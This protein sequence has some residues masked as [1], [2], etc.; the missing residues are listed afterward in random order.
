MTLKLSF[1]S[2]SLSSFFFFFFFFLGGGTFLFVLCIV[3]SFVC[4]RSDSISNPN[5]LCV[6]S[7]TKQNLCVVY[8]K[9]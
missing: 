2:L 9:T 6:H 3:V 1:L 5:R 7:R 8:L 4:Q